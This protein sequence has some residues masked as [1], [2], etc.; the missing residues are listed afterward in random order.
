MKK[1]TK[2]SCRFIFV[3][4][5]NALGGHWSQDGCHAAISNATYTECHCDHMTS[6]G[7]L[8]APIEQV[9]SWLHRCDN[10][11]KRFHSVSP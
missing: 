9:R 4:Y 8:M 7:V 1:F 5:R 6:Y 2:E 10:H 11:F 3:D